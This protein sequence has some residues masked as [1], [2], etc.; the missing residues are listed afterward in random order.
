M[1]FNINAQIILSQ[2]KNLNNVSK[3][4]SKQLGKVTKIDLKIGNVQQL[5]TLNKQLT[6]LNNSLTKLNSNLSST[7]GSVSALGNSFRGTATGVNNVAKAQNTLNTQVTRTNQSLKNQAGLVGTLGKRFGS[8]AKQATAF[9][10]ISRPIYDLQRAFT[11]AVKDAVKFE[12]EIVRISQV[13]GKTVSQLGSLTTQITQLSKSL[14]ISANELAETSRVIAQAGIRGK[15]LEQV[16]TALARSTLAPTF[17]KI[18]D[19]TEGLI[20]AFGQFGLRGKDAEAVLGSLNKVSKEFAVEAE[21]LISV[22]RRTG[23][24]FA[25]A[26]GD[27][28]GTVTALQ[29]LTAVFTAVRST[30]RESADTIAA[31]LRTIFS[32]IQRRSTI[33]FLKQFGVDLT[34]AQ[35]K[36][37]GIFPAFDQLSQRLDILIKKGD[38]LTLSAIAEELGGIRQ[39]GKLLP[40]IAQF[41]KARKALTAAQKGAVEGLGGDVAKALDTIDNRVKRIRESFSALIRQVFESNAFQG[42][43]KS[44]LSGSQAIIDA[45]SSIFKTIEPIL[46]LL[47]ALGTIKLGKAIGGAVG[48]LGGGLAG[49]AST[50]TGSATAQNTQKTAAAVVSQNTLIN[51]TNS[52]LANMTRQLAN[53]I[54][55]NNS[56]FN[57]LTAQAARGRS[58]VVTGFA[59][60]RRRASGGAIPKFANGGRVHGPSHAAGGVIAELEGG[61][62]VVP[63]KYAKG[64]PKTVRGGQPAKEITSRKPIGI[65]FNTA[66]ENDPADTTARITTSQVKNPARKAQLEQAG[67][68]ALNLSNVQTSVFSESD[69]FKKAEKSIRNSFDRAGKALGVDASGPRQKADLA[70]GQLFEDFIIKVVGVKSPSIANFDLKGSSAKQASKFANERPL[71]DLTDIKLNLGEASR[72]SVV[73]KALNEGVFDS[74]IKNARKRAAGG[75]IQKLA[76]GDIVRANSVGAA[77]LDPDDV[78]DGSTKVSVADVE[79][80]L[81]FN[82]GTKKGFSGVGKVFSGKTYNIIRQGLNKQTSD[83]FNKVLAEGLIKGVDFAASELSGD[84]GLGPT[85]IDQASKTKFIQSQRSAIRGDLFEAALSSLSNRGRFDSAVDFARPFDFPDGLKGPF[86]DN[87]SKLP[88][89]FVDAKSSEAAAPDANFRSKIIR[90]IAA[91]VVKQDPNILAQRD[92]QTGGKSTKK[93]TKSARGFG[94]LTFA[95]GGEV[96]VRISNG[97]MVVTDPR[98]VAANK[99]KL[100]SINKLATGGFASGTIAKGPGTGT[101]DSIYT[102]LPEGAFV[103]NAASTKK[104][105]GLR[106]GGGVGAFR[107]GG[108]NRAGQAT[109]AAQTTGGEAAGAGIGLLF[110]VQSLTAS[111]GDASSELNNFVNV[112][113]T[114]VFASQALGLNFQNIG[115]LGG[116]LEG[117]LGKIPG[118]GKNLNLVQGASSSLTRDP[119]SGNIIKT[120]LGKRIGGRIA[121]RAAT[122]GGVGGTAVAAIG[123]LAGGAAIGKIIGDIAGPLI[124]DSV[125]GKQQEVLGVKGSASTAQAQTR[126]AVEGGVKGAST[127]IG[128]GAGLGFVLGGPVGAA[129]GAAIGGVAGSIIGSEIGAANAVYQQEVFKAA[130]AFKGAS[131]DVQKSLQSIGQEATTT[132]FAQLAKDLENQNVKFGSAV[133]KFESKFN[134]EISVAGESLSILRGVTGQVADDG[135]TFFDALDGFFGT[136]LSA[137]N[138][139]KQNSIK[140][141]AEAGKLF[142]PEQLQGL[143]DSLNTGLEKFF[144][145]T[146][147]SGIEGLDEASASAADKLQAAADAGNQLAQSLIR[148]QDETVRQTL[149]AQQQQLSE[150]NAQQRA[151]G[152]AL[153]PL[154]IDPSILRNQQRFDQFIQNTNASIADS[155]SVTQSWYTDVL[156]LNRQI[157]AARDGSIGYAEDLKEQIDAQNA[158]AEAAGNY[159]KA[160]N[161]VTKELNLAIKQL[162]E[163]ISNLNFTASQSS[164]TLSTLEA[165]ISAI[166]AGTGAFQLQSFTNPFEGTS[167]AAQAEANRFFDFI[168]TN[169]SEAGA[170]GLRTFNQL[171]TVFPQLVEETVNAAN[172]GELGDQPSSEVLLGDLERRLGAQGFRLPQEVSDFLQSGASEQGTGESQVLPVARLQELTEAGQIGK[173]LGE[174]FDTAQKAVDNYVDK[175]NQLIKQSET[176]IKI[177]VEQLRIQ[178]ELRK[179]LTDLNSAAKVREQKILEGS[180][181]GARGRAD[182]VASAEANVRAKSRAIGGSSNVDELLGR[183]GAALQAQQ[184]LANQFKTGAI[185]LDEYKKKQIELNNEIASTTEA[186]NFLATETETY[187][188]ILEQAG[189]ITSDIGALEGGLEKTI[190]A[191]ASGD[192][193][194]Q[195]EIVS[196]QQSIFAA[197]Q[198]VASVPQALQALQALGKEENRALVDAIAG[199]QDAGTD[200]RQLLLRQ[201][202]TVAERGGGPIGAALSNQLNA[203]AIFEQQQLDLVRKAEAIQERQ[204]K[205]AEGIQAQNNTRI[206]PLLD[207]IAKNNKTFQDEFNAAVTDFATAVTQ[208]Q[209]TNLIP[210][211]LSDVEQN[212]KETAASTFALENGLPQEIAGQASAIRDNYNNMT[213]PWVAER[214]RQLNELIKQATDANLTPEQR[215]AAQQQVD[216]A[217]FAELE[218]IIT[219]SESITGSQTPSGRSF[220][221]LNTEGKIDVRE[222]QRFLTE[223][224]RTP[225]KFKELEKAVQDFNASVD[226]NRNQRQRQNAATSENRSADEAFTD[227][228]IGGLAKGGPIFQ[229]RGTDTVPAM[230]T[231]GEF[232]IKKSSVDQYGPGVMEA[233]NSGNA[234]VYAASGGRVGRGVLYA[235]GGG[236][237]T[238]AGKPSLSATTLGLTREERQ[239]FIDEEIEIYKNAGTFESA[240]IL[241]QF[242]L[243]PRQSGNI[244]SGSAISNVKLREIAADAQKINNQLDTLFSDKLNLNNFADID[245][246]ERGNIQQRDAISIA[247]RKKIIDQ[248]F[249]DRR[250]PL[251][252]TGFELSE[253]ERKSFGFSGDGSLTINKNN[254]GNNFGFEFS[255]GEKDL[256]AA[257]QTFS[258]STTEFE[259]R[260]KLAS[261]GTSPTSIEQAF[262][263]G[264]SY[265]EAE[266]TAAQ[267]ARIEKLKQEGKRLEEQGKTLREKEASRRQSVGLRDF[268]SEFEKDLRAPVPDS[269]V[270]EDETPAQRA[271]RLRNDELAARA[272]ARKKKRAALDKKAEERRAKQEEAKRR[273]NKDESVSSPTAATGRVS[274][275]TTAGAP[276]A[277]T[278]FGTAQT[279]NVFLDTVRGNK[280]YQRPDGT[281]VNE[282]DQ[283]I[284][285]P[286]AGDAST[287]ERVRKSLQLR[288]RVDRFLEA[289][290]ARQDAIRKQQFDDTVKK[291][292]NAEEKAKFLIDRKNKA[293]G[294][295][296]KYFTEEELAQREQKFQAD[297]KVANAEKTKRIQARDQASQLISQGKFDEAHRVLS[298]AGYNVSRPDVFKDRLTRGSIESQLKYRQDIATGNIDQA[299]PFQTPLS[300]RGV[301]GFDPNI[302]D[303]RA[304]LNFREDFSATT[305]D[306]NTLTSSRPTTLVGST[307]RTPVTFGETVVAAE[308]EK[309]KKKAAGAATTGVE[310]LGSFRG[311]TAVGSI[312]N[313]GVGSIGGRGAGIGRPITGT[314][315]TGPETPTPGLTEQRAVDRAFDQGRR[316]RNRARS[317]EVQQRANAAVGTT[318]FGADG[319]VSLG[320]QTPLSRSERAANRREAKAVNAFRIQFN[321]AILSGNYTAAQNIAQRYFNSGD[322]SQS[323]I[324]SIKQQIDAQANARAITAQLYNK[325]GQVSN[326]PIMAQT[327]EFVMNRQAVQRNG[328]GMLSRMNQGLPTFHS[329]G[330]VSGSTQYR[331]AGGRIFGRQNN[332]P[333]SAITVNGSDAAKELNNAII[334]GGETVRQSWQTLF[335]TVAEGLN[336]A[337]T[338]VST[339]PNQIN[340]TIAPVQIEG[341][342]GFTEALAAQLVP[343]IIEQIAPLINT[344]NNGGSTQQ[345]A[346]V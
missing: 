140:A 148:L 79:A 320:T 90:E 21:D 2:P 261:E 123:G 279:G 263:S 221:I 4:I 284:G 99:G 125:T 151:A 186:L 267:I 164:N 295:P 116:K 211:D 83:R 213:S 235:Q 296:L 299:T 32:R 145:E 289:D 253:D 72:E 80:Q 33:N 182:T 255:Q 25:Q 337:L 171:R 265:E 331:Q 166:N 63:K 305:P 287:L 259:R 224:E 223:I 254:I 84:L 34:D 92:K 65:L 77:I 346:G 20:A 9:G 300:I 297:A 6:T 187:S 264:I 109:G 258:L 206:I 195:R 266:K 335:D 226:Q 124:A 53:L 232:V 332:A 45:A 317:A 42:F 144:A 194:A 321:R 169:F 46:P 100:Q 251:G 314:A 57:T 220:D 12:R 326:V 3:Q 307:N 103:V 249:A 15:D 68:T 105:L 319:E 48:G 173:V 135:N 23:G 341:V 155:V 292:E 241:A 311:T 271:R 236:I 201:L 122:F 26:A 131:D 82:K 174:S 208:F 130:K 315:I 196:D 301:P 94:A 50:V 114:A 217:N 73:R 180:V 117:V 246:N 212:T 40:A 115:A 200:L 248:R 112:I 204:A 64:S 13:T 262:S 238:R 113:G 329:G 126:G 98:E 89:K 324:D 316:A 133:K 152:A 272:D 247:D 69:T 44:F 243:I 128:A 136:S 260:R 256:I 56:G 190:Q 228:K 202:A 30:T 229:P 11:G 207:D 189:K 137:A 91:D 309:I 214:E 66:N 36:F 340:A 158:A 146:D 162:N 86:A 39:I 302:P 159:N 225:E 218:R 242:G 165:N 303:N 43:A 18:T 172:A 121:G 219:A 120:P 216:I 104:Y 95:S 274:T 87:F 78:V 323:T 60:G 96:P 227:R 325:G 285:L 31:G 215:A 29:E 185:T 290:D 239:R 240:G 291:A 181:A 161:T 134:N 147:F 338:Q 168:G 52:T 176:E 328:I 102:T 7:R 269:G 230:L 108:L 268:R 59:G 179:T 74:N 1:A 288:S 47:T 157:Q 177:N 294:R 333:S 54:Q 10:L 41:D 127:G 275:P 330:Y 70:I 286:P 141:F 62:Y 276:V 199:R 178:R 132:G 244:V 304:D 283:P 237:A 67:I 107:R 222:L 27:S 101:S 142:N 163:G 88:N 198:G 8:V 156:T 85:T 327:G 209:K 110:A 28:K 278:S 308:S 5:T 345:G 344:N 150:G 203:L 17:G 322:I 167:E 233:I 55:I 277:S 170:E 339:I 143:K 313:R 252:L 280:I 245:L 298:G 14:G 75:I 93:K 306:V 334:T 37:V 16:L 51:T 97:E 336:S 58:T 312:G 293:N 22:I 270:P 175:A 273:R 49:A 257:G 81:G 210:P 205:A 281:L 343:K 342:G 24:V 111:F 19:T 118:V 139:A 234:Q 282:K 154:I 192:V 183:R 153:T 35:G 106:R 250:Q 149:I 191:I 310:F 61:E 76:T 38:A 231:P 138:Q 318:T 129:I 197:I 71:P 184:E 119:F 188:A 160:I 193:G